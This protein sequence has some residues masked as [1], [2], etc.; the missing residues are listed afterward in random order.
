MAK[1]E[2]S[3]QSP[4]HSISATTHVPSSSP[5]QG[6]LWAHRIRPDALYRRLLVGDGSRRR[7]RRR[8][9]PAAGA[10]G[11]GTLRGPLR[12]LPR[13]RRSRRPGPRG[14]EGRHAGL[15]GLLL[16]E[17]GAG[18]PVGRRDP[19]RRARPRLQGADAPSR[20]GAQPGRSRSL[21][22]PSEWLQ[23][24]DARTRRGAHSGRDRSAPLPFAQ[25]LHRRTLAARRAEP[26][27][28]AGH[29][30]SLSRR[31]GGDHHLCQCQ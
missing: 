29:R 12:R 1:C 31:R 2:V 3:W 23:G 15:R 20:R 11:E 10:S 18:C 14:V 19:Q 28:A 27:P 7:V 6:P 21:P 5:T 17:P 30:E 16:C 22:R 9:E 24:A 8:W 13:S 4:V 25:L 26:A